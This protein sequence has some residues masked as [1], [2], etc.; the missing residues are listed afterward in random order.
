M[1][2]GRSRARGRRTSPCGFAQVH[3]IDDPGAQTMTGV[4]RRE[5][6]GTLACSAAGVGAEGAGKPPVIDT[7]MHVWAD[8]K[9]RFP[10]AHPYEPNFKPPRL[11]ATVEM[12]LKE[13]DT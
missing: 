6:L 8:D 11:A 7:H 1:P 13:M 5:F 3:L 4:S 10:F 9:D 2:S 12:L